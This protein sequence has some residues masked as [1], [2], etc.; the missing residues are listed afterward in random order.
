MNTLFPINNINHDEYPNTAEIN[1]Y[2]DNLVKEGYVLPDSDGS[3][4][5]IIRNSAVLN[6]S[7]N[8]KLLNESLK[9]LYF[10]NSNKLKASNSANVNFYSWFG[11]MEDVTII[12]NTL[13]CQIRIATENIINISDRNN[14]KI[15]Q[16]FRKWIDITDILNNYDTF[17]F[18]ILL[19]INQRI[20]SEYKFRIDDKETIL[21]FKFNE[22]WLKNNYPIYIYKFDT[23]AQCR[24]KITN[25]LVLNQWKWKLP[26][27]YITDKR[28][29]Q[30]KHF[31]CTFNRIQETRSDK[32]TVD[33]IG[34]NIEFLSVD[35]K[36]YIDLSNIS[37]KNKNII[38]SEPKEW[39]YMSIIVPKYFHEYPILLPT[40]VIYR[41]YSSNMDRIAVLRNQQA[42]FVKSQNEDLK[43]V[44]VDMGDG[45]ENTESGWKNLIRPIVLSDSFNSPEIEMYDKLE[46]EL[47]PLRDATVE[48]AN[49]YENFRF[50]LKQSHTSEE[51]IEYCNSLITNGKKIKELYTNFL[52]KHQIDQDIVYNDLF[53]Y[54][55]EIIESLKIKQDN[56]E[57]LITKANSNRNFFHKFS[58]IIYTPRL[59]VD[60]YYI[61]QLIGQV[62]NRFIQWENVDELAYKLRFRRPIE[63]TDFWTFEYDFDNKVWKPYPL[64]IEHHFPDVY[65]PTESDSTKNI[66]NRIFKTFFFYSDTINELD[67]TTD[68]EKS[69]PSWDEDIE[70]YEIDKR[71]NYQDIFMGK[72]YWMGVKSIYKNILNTK[73]RWEAIEYVIDN[74]SYDRFN[75]LF[76]KLAD[77]YFK[78]GLATYLRSSNNE[79]PFD[80]AIDKMNE[81]INNQLNNYKRITAYE[82]YLYKTWSPQYFDSLFTI[83]DTNKIIEDN[84]LYRPDYSFDIDRVIP[85]IINLQNDI[86]THIGNLEID[87]NWI[88]EKLSIENYNLI[89]KYYTDLLDNLITIQK[90]S[91]I[92]LDKINSLDLAIY[93]D[94]EVNEIIDCIRLHEENVNNISNLLSLIYTD[95]NEKDICQI[96]D[97]LQDQLQTALENDVGYQV[98]LICNIIN[99]FNIDEFMRIMNELSV[100][101]V[102]NKETGEND[103]SLIGYLNKFN[104]AWANSVKQA[105]ND[106]F[107][108]TSLL[109]AKFDPDKSYTEEEIEDFINTMNTTKSNL[110][111]LDKEINQYWK[112]FDQERDIELLTKLDNAFDIIDKLEVNIN[113]Y[114]DSRKDLLESFDKVYSILDEFEKLYLGNTEKEFDTNIRNY[115]NKILYYV[116]YIAGA[117]K[118]TEANSELQNAVQESKKW[119]VFIDVMYSVFE[120]IYSISNDTN[121]FVTYVI[122][123]HDIL[124][125]LMNYLNRVNEDYIEFDNNPNYSD[126][127]KVTEVKLESGGILHRYGDELFIPHLGSY[128]ITETKD[129]IQRATLIE[130]LDYYNWQLVNPMNNP[131]LYEGI[132]NG[133]GIG[134]L[135]KPISVEH[136][137]YTDNSLAKSY[138]NEII[139]ILDRISENVPNPNRYNNKFL[140]SILNSISIVKDKWIITKEK[141]VNHIDQETVDYVDTT[142]R[143]IEKIGRLCN[144]YIAIRDKINVDSIVNNIR[145][146]IETSYDYAT[147]NN[148]V[149]LEYNFYHKRFLSSFVNL[150]NFYSNGTDWSNG[151]ELISIL[152]DIKYELQIYYNWDIED[153]HQEEFNDLFNSIMTDIN[154]VVENIPLL[155]KEYRP[156]LNQNNKLSRNINEN[157]N[158]FELQNQYY[159]INNT[160][161]GDSGKNYKIG[162]IVQ[163][164]YDDE[165]I[166]FQIRK[167]DSNGEVISAVPLMNYSLPFQLAGSY[168]TITRVGNGKG[169]IINVSCRKITSSLFTIL[170]DETS[171]EFIDEKYNESD[172]VRFDLN[173]IYDLNTAYEVF[174]SGLQTSDFIIRHANNKDSIYLNANKVMNIHNNSI[175]I[176][177]KNYFIYKINDF[178]IQ[179]SG[180]GYSKNQDIYIDGSESVTKA[181]ISELDNTPFR[182]IKAINTDETSIIVEKTD[183]SIVNG[184]VIKDS[185]NNIDDEFNNGYYDKI[186]SDGITKYAINGK[187]KED[188]IYTAYRY[189]NLEDADR[190]KSF[191]HPKTDYDIIEDVI[192]PISGVI[193]ISDNIPPNQS[194]R[195]EFQ[196]LLRER[197]CNNGSDIEGY[198]FEIL[199][200]DTQDWKYG[201]INDYVIINND[202][203]FNGHRT[204]YRIRS[205][206]G[207]NR[208]IYDSPIIVDREWN[209]FH[210]DFC[211]IDSYN[212]PSLQDI[213]E[214]LDFSNYKSFRDIE[215]DISLNKFNKKINLQVG[216]KTYIHQI[217]IS[218]ISVYNYT[219]KQ[220]EDLSDN[221]KW[222]LDLFE[223]GFELIYHND[224]MHNYDMRLYLNKSAYTQIKNENLKR[225]AIVSIKSSIVDKVITDPIN[226]SINTNNNVKIRKLLPFEQRETFTLGKSYG[227]EINFKLANYMHYKNEIHLEDIKIFNKSANRFENLLDTNLFEVRFKDDK[228]YSRG[229]E[230]QTR[231]VSSVVAKMGDEFVNGDVWCYNEFYDTHVF[232][233][234]TTDMSNN[235]S[236]ILTFKPLHF[237]NPPKEN[238]TL[239]F[240]CYQRDSQSKKQCGRI[241]IEFVT[242]KVEVYGDGYIHNVTNRLAPV[243]E[244]FKIICLYNL[245]E[246]TEYEVII[247]K[248]PRVYTFLDSRWIM[249]PKLHISDYQIPA[250]RIYLMTERGRFPLVN[251][252]TEKPSLLVEETSDGTDI[253]FLNLYKAYEK[254]E[255]HIVPYPMRS[256]Y[257]QYIVPANGYI[258]LTGKLNKP[259]NKKYY[260]FWMNGRLLDDEVTIITPTKLILHGLQSL[261]NFEIV[262]I[263]RDSHEYFSDNFIDVEFTKYDRPYLR[264]NLTTY[265]DDALTGDL[266]G[267]N[268]TL[269]EQEALLSPVWKQVS[270]DDENFK[271]YPINTDIERDILTRVE[272]TD[273]LDQIS[274]AIYQY[275]VINTPTIEGRPFADRNM[276][277]E[278][279]KY[280]PITD[281]M[282]V[283]MLN[284]VWSEEIEN[285]II[286]ERSIIG[287]NDWYGFATKM[288]NEFGE[289]VTNISEAAYFITDD[290]I[291]KIDNNEKD[292]RIIRK[293]KEYDLD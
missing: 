245:Y 62:K 195:N 47:K 227:Y 170:W 151:T 235:G 72:F 59:L 159:Y 102:Y 7:F 66:T 172:L 254:L 256:V 224:E 252:S 225:N 13:T 51:F 178:T 4:S 262:E 93:A 143:T 128:R 115:I 45:N 16:F 248:T 260:E 192:D 79:F 148:L 114:M 234:V 169:V 217:K 231:I 22:R 43:Q 288:Y 179:D 202:P 25:E 3:K 289:L 29:I 287:S 175:Y 32:K 2:K 94:D 78:M 204:A 177:E 226:I 123:Y 193:P 26:L 132:T 133:Y 184:E 83:D 135:V 117:N 156:I 145:L 30:D 153:L 134:I 119:N 49:T 14:F 87:V 104:N 251:P 90:N 221:S 271:K 126:F 155:I 191:T 207:G 5:S 67:P 24:I 189:D 161:I 264:Y 229:Y 105:R 160:S 96:K 118:S 152:K 137:S 201:K 28:I 164:Q 63:T 150:D 293:E 95:C 1:E 280:K 144:N 244:E 266:E 42:Y 274:E 127:Y 141:C 243:P 290:N 111:K 182:G 216:T 44:Y 241:N 194:D 33:V 208:Y 27:D 10:N 147:K 18:A 283:D 157:N 122:P 237:I 82:N 60:K 103:I 259:L 12:P 273:T 125:S 120:R 281:E 278:Q 183:P 258:D 139:N 213:Y 240:D 250:D 109:Y 180:A 35:D 71:G 223:Y 253:T 187:D 267:D 31:I 285:N 106:F 230:N 185:I 284:E 9:E 181:Y 116:S 57:W 64:S 100:Y 88:I 110:I 211:N 97:N 269:E 275:I 55:L 257:T 246:E 190:N 146:L 186:T 163:L 286:G 218:D 292:S 220:W 276:T 247:S 46:I 89:F 167:I 140:D 166:L 86:S 121:I 124:V 99:D 239:Q 23:N 73:Y 8:E 15:K 233:T 98:S 198:N 6:N 68:I 48:L 268:Y 53:D 215:K 154:Y 21:Q 54:Y 197:I 37:E 58:P 222:T 168:K 209:K 200:Y 171:D 39:M 173:N 19:F 101:K 17:H 142:F 20:Y 41:S 212:L 80:Y 136:M 91:K 138:I 162:D 205:F 69:S 232:G 176:P 206:S 219:L 129:N 50:F 34:E 81:A 238:L 61:S 158:L 92:L 113:K 291:L 77:P 203:N 56:S 279:F 36:G 214:G 112:Y 40:D 76:I 131:N 277:L 270:V 75:K 249:S 85:T 282:I 84:I 65:I 272:E 188:Y 38:Y 196:F 149:N 210:I 236:G 174:I 130:S 255:F 108:S 199:P 228:A 242:E 165:V 107:I 263:N 11:T 265:L 74:K 70:R 52:Y 261:R